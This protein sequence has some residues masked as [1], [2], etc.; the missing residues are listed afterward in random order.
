MATKVVKV[1]PN[2]LIPGEG[3]KHRCVCKELN[4]ADTNMRCG[5]KVQKKGARC[6]WCR[7]NCVVYG[8]LNKR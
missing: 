3:G 8:P 1:D 5:N 2:L 7:M 4:H 6:E